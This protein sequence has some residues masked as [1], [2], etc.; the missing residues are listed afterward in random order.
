MNNETTTSSPNDSDAPVVCCLSPAEI[1]EGNKLIAKFM[2][3]SVKD[4]KGAHWR[5]IELDRIGEP[6]YN[7][8]L[9]KD[10]QY[11]SSWDWLMPIYKKCY[12]IW[13][14]N[15]KENKRCAEIFEDIWHSLWKYNFENFYLEIVEFIKWYNQNVVSEW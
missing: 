1:E 8:Q 4:F 2:K 6:Y 5:Y 3:Y 14:P 7:W 13:I 15:F 9:I 10:L 12:D 11:H